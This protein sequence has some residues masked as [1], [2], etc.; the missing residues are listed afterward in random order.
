[1]YFYSEYILYLKIRLRICLILVI[2]KEYFDFILIKY[3]LHT[4]TSIQL[5][6]CKTTVLQIIRCIYGDTK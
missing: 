3:N 1:M 2:T 5:L 4:A 6:S